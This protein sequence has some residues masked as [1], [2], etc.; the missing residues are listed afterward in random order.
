MNDSG[1]FQDVESNY[2]GKI[3]HVPSQPAVV[4]SPRSM[5]KPRQTQ[6]FETWNLSETSGKRFW[7]STS[8]V[9]FITDTLS[10]NS[11]LYDS[12][13]YRYDSSAGRYRATCRE[14]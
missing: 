14:R 13:C 7:Q 10:R 12:K 5:L 11:S 2:S 1:E 9:R 8:Y 6:A 3:S 4:P